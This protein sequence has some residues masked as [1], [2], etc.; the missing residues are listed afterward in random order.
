[1]GRIKTA[2]C[3]ARLRS[4]STVRHLVHCRACTLTAIGEYKIILQLVTVLSHGKQAKRLT[5]AA[6][7]QMEGVQNL[8][9]AVYDFKLQVDAAEPGS[10]K[11][12]AQQYRAVNYLYR[13]GT[14]IVLANFLLEAKEAGTPL[15]Q[16]DFPSWMQQHREI[17]TVLSRKTLD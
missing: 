1:M 2:K 3:L 17:R 15:D 9:K 6:I 12:R 13:Y 16:T 5:D 11:Q 10:A 8:R 4:I 7:N 14:L